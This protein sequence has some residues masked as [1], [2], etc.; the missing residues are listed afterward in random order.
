M[1]RITALMTRKRVGTAPWCPWLRPLPYNWSSVR[2]NLDYV[3]SDALSSLCFLLAIQVQLGWHALF[4]S[5][6]MTTIRSSQSLWR[7]TLSLQFRHLWR[8]REF[9]SGSLREVNT[10]FKLIEG[11]H[12]LCTSHML[13]YTDVSYFAFSHFGLSIF[14]ILYFALCSGRVYGSRLAGRPVGEGSDYDRVTLGGNNRIGHYTVTHYQTQNSWC[15][16]IYIVFP[17]NK[18][19]EPCTKYIAGENHYWHQR[20]F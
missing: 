9:N 11:Q 12:I 16:K 6:F 13:E 3:S 7:Q 2:K 14:R 17:I 8:T 15:T 1:T 10:V 20:C 5:F 18:T 4:W 19:K